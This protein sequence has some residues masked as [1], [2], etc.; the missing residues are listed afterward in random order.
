M[1]VIC[2][3]SFAGISID[4]GSIFSA[5]APLFVPISSRVANDNPNQRVSFGGTLHV[6]VHECGLLYM[7]CQ[8]SRYKSLEVRC[9]ASIKQR[10]GK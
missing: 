9:E 6:K 5:G 8:E 1:V 2:M 7:W 3:R 4:M 10:K